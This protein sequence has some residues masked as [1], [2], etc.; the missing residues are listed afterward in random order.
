MLNTCN[1]HGVVYT[2][3]GALARDCQIRF[4]V[5]HR[6]VSAQDSN[7]IVPRAVLART[8]ASGLL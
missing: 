7:T 6:R 4:L 8:D 5:A 1:V 3:D 2:P